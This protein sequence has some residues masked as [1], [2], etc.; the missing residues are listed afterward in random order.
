MAKDI[1][2]EDMTRT[3]SHTVT[4]FLVAF[5]GTERHPCLLCP[6]LNS[7]GKFHCTMHNVLYTRHPE[8]FFD[9]VDEYDRVLEC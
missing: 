3:L 2:F 4:A 1:Y 5:S 8:R 7:P 9:Y 6:L